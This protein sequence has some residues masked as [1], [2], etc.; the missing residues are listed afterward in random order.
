M[1]ELG[2]RLSDLILRVTSRRQ[3]FTP[4]NGKLPSRTPNNG[5]P[6][7]KPLMWGDA[8]EK[9][10][11]NNDPML[12]KTSENKDPM[13]L[14]SAAAPGHDSPPPAEGTSASQ[15]DGMNATA[16]TGGVAA[17]NVKRLS[18]RHEAAVSVGKAGVGI[19]LR[20]EVDK[21]GFVVHRIRDG[22]PAHASGE[23]QVRP[24][25][26]PWQWM[27]AHRAYFGWWMHSCPCT[28]VHSHEKYE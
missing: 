9:R 19:D 25:V 7:L 3:L 27:Q 21:G 8:A 14:R 22:S 5:T 15:S 12:L 4:V 13:L 1:Q 20:L 23:V 6:P 18:G 24:L 2:E 10:P 11:E 16:C 28:L 26:P 17:A